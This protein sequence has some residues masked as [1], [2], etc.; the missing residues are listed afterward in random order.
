MQVIKCDLQTVNVK[1]SQNSQ[2]FYYYNGN[3]KAFVL[4]QFMDFSLT[5]L[6]SEI[7]LKWSLPYAEI[8]YLVLGI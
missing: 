8:L 1:N 3:L 2:K 6:F 4:H 7:L 5:N